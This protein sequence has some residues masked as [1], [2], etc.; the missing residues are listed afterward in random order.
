VVSGDKLIGIVSRGDIVNA[1]A[2]G[3]LIIR[4]W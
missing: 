1:V 3:H 4:P 2:E